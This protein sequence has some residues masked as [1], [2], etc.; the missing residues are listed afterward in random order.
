MNLTPNDV[1]MHVPMQT[2]MFRTAYR[3]GFLR[4]HAKA[5]LAVAL[6]VAMLPAT[7]WAHG[8]LR[9]SEPAEGAHL[10]VAP[11]ALRLTFTE[12][13]ELHFARLALSGP[14]GPVVL[15]TFALAPDSATVLVA[16]VA[17][18]LVAGAYTIAWQVAGEDGH[19]VRGQIRFMVVPGAEGLTAVPVGPSA[20]G[21]APPP[22]T[23]HDE[24]TFPSG[25]GF[26]AES[27]L[28]VTVRWLTFLGL[29]GVLGVIAFRLVLWGVHRQGPQFDSSFVAPAATHAARLGLWM[30]GVVALAAVLR[31]YAQSYALHGG[32]AALEPR[33]LGTMLGRTLWGWGWLLQA[34]GTT[35]AAAGFLL[36]RRQRRVDSVNEEVG[37]P[38]SA[39][40]PHG[41]VGADPGGATQIRAVDDEAT[42]VLPQF[43]SRAEAPLAAVAAERS[44]PVRAPA[45]HAHGAPL[46]WWIA[47]LGAVLL[48]LT[49]GMS[50]HAAST[51]R[52][53]PLPVITDAVHVIGAGG[54]LGSLL[55][56]LLVGIPVA[57]KLAPPERGPAVAALVNAFSPTALFFAGAVAATG[58]FAAWLHLGE[59]PALW[60]SAYGRTLLLKLGVLSVVFGTGAYNWLKV[61]PALGDEAAAGRLRRSA[62]VELTVGAVVLAVTAVLVA[63]ATPM[64]TDMGPEDDEPASVAAGR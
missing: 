60:Q 23:H 27:P 9:R 12:A 4:A 39:V 43:P 58:V 17:G 40:T 44:A 54:W 50:G 18:P 35:V 2:T 48:A 47:G 34:A 45:A 10:T 7:A 42:V 55:A 25:G 1:P 30:V 56:V 15:G 57:L 59:V 33:L 14:N 3:R 37:T 62:I 22:A 29:V 19:P 64:G 21:Q 61:K 8:A 38:D 26:D 11:R 52:F 16:P 41:A 32:A 24:A 51:P 49:P 53:A 13:V 31:L 6:L 63:T 36:V 46:G 5:L 20:P 28:Y